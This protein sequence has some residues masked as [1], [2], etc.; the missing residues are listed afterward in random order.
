MSK[1]PYPAV[2]STW[3]TWAPG[4]LATSPSS[5]C[6]WPRTVSLLGWWRSTWWWPSWAVS[7]RSLSLHSL[8]SPTPSS[9]IKQTPTIRRSLAWQRLWVSS[10]CEAADGRCCIST[11]SLSD[12]H[13]AH[14]ATP[15]SSSEPWLNFW[16]LIFHYLFFKWSII[17]PGTD[18]VVQYSFSRW[19]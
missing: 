12:Y 14:T 18:F 13:T 6:S 11:V 9:G 15:S 4:Q 10:R 16:G 7:S 5:R 8:T 3:S 19:W 1:W 2:T 17:Q